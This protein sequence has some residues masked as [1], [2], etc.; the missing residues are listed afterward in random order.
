MSWRGAA[1]AK[2]R[3]LASLPYLLPIVDA[4]PFG[5][6]LLRQFPALAIVFL[7]L[8][9]LLV[10]NSIPFAGLIIFFIL[11]LA[12]VRN[13]QISHFIRFNTMQAILLDIVLSL[14]GLLFSQILLPAL[15]EN[16]LTQT[17]ANVAFLGI[18]AASIY[19]MV[20]SWL[21]RYADIPTLSEAVYTQV[22]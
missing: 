12:V 6:F 2:D 5:L 10:L 11:Y 19:S 18:L 8:Q 14:F 20:Q 7:P 4:L 16:L 15:G 22:P 9:P 1:T 13:P 3:V 17:L 21:G